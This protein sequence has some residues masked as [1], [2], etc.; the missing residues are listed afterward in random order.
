MYNPCLND[1]T[2]IKEEEIIKIGHFTKPHGIKGELSLVTDLDVFDRVDD[3][4][5]ICDMDGIYVPFFVD[6]YRYKT[7]TVVLVKLEDVDSEDEART[8]MGKE[9][10]F[11]KDAVSDEDLEGDASWDAV[12]GFSV[13]DVHK[14]FIGDIVDVDDSTINVLLRVDHDGKEVLI[15]AVDELIVN[16]DQDAENITVDLPEG[17]LEL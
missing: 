5:V 12:I 7:D 8:F 15:P 4:C 2:M 13:K 9:V 1:V 16:I 10:Y 6:S 14:G 3:P 11:P 17:L